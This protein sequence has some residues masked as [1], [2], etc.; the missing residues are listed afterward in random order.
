MAVAAVLLTFGMSEGSEL[1]H[2]IDLKAVPMSAGQNSEYSCP[3]VPHPLVDMADMFTFYRASSTNSVVDR[4][5]MARYVERMQPVIDVK[6]SLSE[7]A[8]TALVR[9]EVRA[10]AADCAR[11]HLERWAEAGAF[12]HNLDQN[13][14][15]DRR[16]AV[17]EMIWAAIAF[18][19]A[20]SIASQIEPLPDQVAEATNDWLDR[21]IEEII[22][23][24]S[25][26]RD[27]P[28]ERWL[29]DHNNHWLWAAAGVGSM[30]VLVQD[31]AAF[32]WSM[33]ILRTALDEA[34][35]DG[36][37]PL[38]MVRGARSLSYQSFAT[39]AIGILVDLADTNGV[40]LTQTQEQRL[41]SIATFTADGYESPDMIRRISGYEQE[42]E[43]QM[44]G[45]TAS[46]ADHFLETDPA[47]AERLISIS[48]QY[49]IFTAD[50]CVDV[51]TAYYYAKG[52]L[53]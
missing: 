1:R 17:L 28:S 40:H 8:A 11:D 31:R 41:Q 19:N 48:V 7:M 5:R 35:E 49:G 39:R 46:L 16:Q 25:L 47:L 20:Y 4:E 30:A 42:R 10:S 38:E 37:L 33:Q 36:S 34:P 29:N 24:F 43:P 51:C 32:D 23:D 53:N 26:R 13:S 6:A 2:P 9:P 22:A 15:L 14:P 3:E 44:L 21:M 18:S 45:W 52:T 27:E 12:L 50:D